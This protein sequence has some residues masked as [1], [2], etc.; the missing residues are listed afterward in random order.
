MVGAS[1]ES[2]TVSRAVDFEAKPVVARGLLPEPT[3]LAPFLPNPATL[4]YSSV[5]HRKVHHGSSH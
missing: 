4:R 3:D 2:V 5:I 1:A